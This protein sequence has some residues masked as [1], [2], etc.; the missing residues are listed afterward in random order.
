[1]VFTWGTVIPTGFAW[2]GTFAIGVIEGR[3]SAIG[4]VVW[5]TLLCVWV[6]A[7]MWIATHE[8]IESLND[9]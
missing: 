8:A 1:M 2:T 6:V 3:G 5:P 7:G 4:L 9:R